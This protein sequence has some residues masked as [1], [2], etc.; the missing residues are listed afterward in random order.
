MSGQLIK[1]GIA[2]MMLTEEQI[3]LLRK[4][5]CRDLTNDEFEL[6]VN[7]CKRTGLDPFAK[8]I[9]PV[10]RMDKKNDRAV[11]AIQTSIDGFRVVAERTGKYG[12]QDGPYW[13]DDSGEW[14]DVWLKKTPPIA[15]K[16]GVYRQDWKHPC[17]GIARFDAYAQKAYGKL[18]LFWDKMPD[19]MIAKC[20]ESL[21]LRKA[22]PHDLSGLYTSE[23]MSQS[24][25]PRSESDESSESAGTAPSVGL[26]MIQELLAK[27]PES[28]KADLFQREQISAIE[29]MKTARV[30]PI[31]AKLKAIKKILALAKEKQAD[32]QKTLAHF[33]VNSLVELDRAQCD[34][35]TSRLTEK[36]TPEPASA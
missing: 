31:I 21:A 24:D 1:T 14:K 4:T 22:F 8:Q 23:E 7:Q 17:Y 29:D 3:Q 32:L 19:L 18:T 28:I 6:F 2:P 36:S 20:A 33:K 16:V 11:L 27:L 15:A 13:C 12:G 5:L 34:L 30:E 9:Y 25:D 10:K 35:V 26:L